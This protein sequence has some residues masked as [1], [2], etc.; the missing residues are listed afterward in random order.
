M[1]RS[2]AIVLGLVALLAVGY[3]AASPYLAVRAMRDAAMAGDAA[4]VAAHV[5]FP[6]VKESLK[7][8]LAASMM[9]SAG[10]DGDENPMAGAGAMF[11][12]A[13]VGP[14]IDAMVSPDGLAALMKHGALPKP[15]M[16]GPEDAPP[17]E[18]TAQARP[19][20][21]MR[22]RDLNT[23]VVTLGDDAGSDAPVGLVFRRHGLTGWK[24]TSLDL[25][26]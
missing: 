18:P 15:A 13:L 22:Y 16:F 3:V 5:D 24:L 2:T 6:A 20:A 25:P 7:A 14:M 10:H 12:M 19:D 4:G 26:R 17:A 23:F 11:A 1:K 9:K 21:R 8:N